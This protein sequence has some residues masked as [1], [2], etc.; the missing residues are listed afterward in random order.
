MEGECLCKAVAVKVND[1]NLFGEQRRGHFCHCANCRKVAGGI[2]G[3]NLTI[4][5]EKVE[6]PKGKGNLKQY[7]VRR[8]FHD[9]HHPRSPDVCSLCS[10][11]DNFPTT[12]S[13]HTQ[14]DPIA[15]TCGVPIMSV[16]PLYK[17]KVVLKLGL[18]TYH[19]LSAIPLTRADMI[20][21]VCARAQYPK[22]PVPEWESF[23]S[24]RQSWEK[25]LEGTIQYKTKSFGEKMP[26]SI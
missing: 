5:E 11:R 23:A 26:G 1:D 2:F 24:Q 25:P 13:R 20:A 9:L 17:G 4:E 21:R 15:T 18:V 10:N 8:P 6:F 3:A 12:G 16:T 22:L 7:T 19:C 14:R